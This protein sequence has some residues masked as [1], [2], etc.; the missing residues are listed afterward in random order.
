MNITTASEI[1]ANSFV[2]TWNHN[3]ETN[4]ASRSISVSEGDYFT[5]F[6]EIENVPVSGSQLI[7]GLKPDTLYR[8]FIESSYNN[9]DI[10]GRDGIEVRTLPE[11]PPEVNPKVTETKAQTT[12]NKAVLAIVFFVVL[13][14]IIAIAKR[15]N[16]E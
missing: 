8:A 7:T 14:F 3:P 13:G 10:G 16:N 12:P 15:V 11:T 4:V 1:T 9:S 6:Y 5:P 2:I